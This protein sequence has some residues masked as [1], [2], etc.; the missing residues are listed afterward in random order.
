MWIIITLL[1]SIFLS[2]YRDIFNEYLRI[3]FID[4]IFN[5]VN[6]VNIVNKYIVNSS[7]FDGFLKGIKNLSL[8]IMRTEKQLS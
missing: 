4:I 8:L 1:Q 3:R 7:N 2:V 5:M 6:M